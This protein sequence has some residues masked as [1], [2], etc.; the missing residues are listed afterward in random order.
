MI[1]C[2]CKLTVAICAEGKWITLRNCKNIMEDI[3]EL[4]FDTMKDSLMCCTCQRCRDDVLAIALNQIPP[5]YVVTEAGSVMSKLELLHSQPLADVRAA[6]MRAS[7][8]VGK[9]PHH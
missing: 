9:N 5:R 2:E 1:H 6:L 4:E 7:L 3:L 8:V